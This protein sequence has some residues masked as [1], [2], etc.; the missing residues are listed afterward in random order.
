M[1]RPVF[2]ILIYYIAGIIAG[3]Y[4]KADAA[5]FVAMVI[6]TLLLFRLKR[7]RVLFALPVFMVLGFALT[8]LSIG[9][10][11]VLA[12]TNITISGVVKDITI[13]ENGTYRIDI[14]TDDGAV[15]VMAY[16]DENLNTG[17]IIEV[18]GKAKIPEKPSN[19]GAFDDYTYMKMKGLKYRLYADNIIKTGKKDMG[20]FSAIVKLRNT[21]NESIDRVYNDENSALIKALVTGD[22]SYISDETRTLYTDGGAIHLLCVSGLHV[23]IIA[24]IIFF[25]INRISNKARLLSALLVSAILFVYMIFIGSAPSVVRAVIMASLM[26]MAKPV[27]RK[28]DG[29][30]NM[31]I[32][33]FLILLGNPLLLFNSGFLLSFATVTGIVLSITKRNENGKDNYFADIL[34][35]SFFA[36]IFALPITAYYFYS[37]SVAGVLT[38]LVVLPLTPVVVI[39]GIVSAVMGVFGTTLGVVAAL[40]AVAVLKVYDIVLNAVSTISLLNGITGRPSVFMCV[41]YYAVLILLIKGDK[42]KTVVKSAIVLCLTVMAAVPVADRFVL[43]NVEVVFLDVGQGDCAVITDYKNNTYVVDT[44]G[45]WYYDEDE[46]TGS[47]YVYPYLQYKGTEEIDILFISHPDYDHAMG[48]LEL[49]DKCTISKIVFA[50]F[51]YTENE[52]YNRIIEKAND[53]NVE[54]TYVSEGDKVIEDDLI[55]ECMYPQKGMEGDDNEGSMVLKF[56]YKDFSVLFTGDLGIAQEVN[57]M[58]NNIEADVLKVAHHG[59]AYSTSKDFIDAVNCDIAVIPAGKNNIYGHPTEEVLER[60]EGKEVFVT[61][62]DGAVTVKTN[63]KDYNVKTEK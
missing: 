48:S 58:D 1:K 50:D 9:E 39:S 42:R 34:K 10:D 37:V 20:Y 53:K 46:N 19:P 38:N 5:L 35:T 62:Y 25:I 18:S 52:L 22:K 23:G 51:D 26:F 40:P 63:G 28:S 17:D 57:L 8:S 24:G 60:L 13:S 59:S 6:T 21:L 54:I 29:L 36:T 11:V 44:G 12:D 33:A 7:K 45:N 14:T 49:M 61:G 32:A 55:F 56:T 43:K 2:I 27:G 16:E 41:I 31:F 30:N 3:R 4:L 47:R 15:R